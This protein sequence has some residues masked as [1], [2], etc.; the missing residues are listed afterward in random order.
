MF[1]KLF[2]M[3]PDAEHLLSLS[4]E[5]LAGPLLVSLEDREQIKPN[6]VISY[7]SM[8]W[9]IEEGSSRKNPNL[10]YPH[11][12]HKD[13]L[14]GLMEAWQWLEREGFVTP[15]PTNTVGYS[16]TATY[17]TEYFI[18]RRGEKI[19]TLED[20]EAYRK[21]DLLRK[22]QL[23]PIIAEKVWSIFAQGSYGTAVLEASK[24]VEIAVRKTG[25]Y[26]KRDYGTDLMRTAFHVDNGKLTDPKQETAEKQAMSDLFAGAIGTYKNPSSHHEVE[27]APEEAAEIIIFASHLLRIVDACKERIV[28]LST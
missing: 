1:S 23:H 11:N 3:L 14:H 15:M 6:E 8:K 12:I 19:Q 17:G 16:T 27:Y 2:E 21:A 28:N 7:R 22:H 13:V 18:S 24:Q 25:G 4:A 9:E 5:E 26:A 10:N 20:Y